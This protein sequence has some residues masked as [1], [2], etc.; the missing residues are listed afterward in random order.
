MLVSS[1]SKA[2]SIFKVSI[3]FLFWFPFF[4]LFLQVVSAFSL[5]TLVAENPFQKT[6]LK[7]TFMMTECNGCLTLS[8]CWWGRIS[9]CKQNR[10]DEWQAACFHFFFFELMSKRLLAFL[11]TLAV[12]SETEIMR[13]KAGSHRDSWSMIEGPQP[14]GDPNGWGLL[15]NIDGVFIGMAVGL[16]YSAGSGRHMGCLL[17]WRW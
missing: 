2:V 7:K 15:I 17:Q 6:V 5:P 11:S 8:R 9:Y 12:H 4:F 1:Y 16:N 3:L 13:R 10:L 14:H